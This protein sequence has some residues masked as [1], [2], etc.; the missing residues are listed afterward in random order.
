MND[1]VTVDMKP[2]GSA[3]AVGAHPDDIDFSCGATLAK[4]AAGGSVIHEVVCTDGSKGSW[5]PATDADALVLARMSEQRAAHQALGGSGQVI[6]L[7]RRD[8]ELENSATERREL[9]ERIRELRPDVVL[10]HDPWRRY[11][12]HRDHRQAGF[13]LIDAVIA[14]RDPLFY[15]HKH[16]APHRVADVLLWKADEIDHLED[17]SGFVDVKVKAL[18]E[19]RSQYQTTLRI[20][21]ASSQAANTE[22][23]R[24]GVLRRLGECGK[25]YGLEL[26]EG[27]KRLSLG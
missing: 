24:A 2:P 27:F 16:A 18:L 7:S 14:A 23:V 21:P 5:D 9:C 13:L 10:G 26:A 19:H 12:L 4:W 17:V 6:F 3:L 25:P 11:L 15:P 1:R 8:G 20:D 22:Q